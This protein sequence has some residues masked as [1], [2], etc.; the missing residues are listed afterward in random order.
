MWFYD[1]G[2][3]VYAWVVR[4]VS[5]RNPKAKLWVEGRK[6]WFRRMTE[7]IDPAARII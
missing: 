2:L 3:I 6:N 7:R 4:L 5:F 1:I